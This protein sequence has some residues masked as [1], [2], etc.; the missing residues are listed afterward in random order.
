MPSPILVCPFFSFAFVFSRSKTP[1]SA[2]VGAGQRYPDPSS[3][4]GASRLGRAQLSAEFIRRELAAFDLACLRVMVLDAFPTA[5]SPAACGDL[6]SRRVRG[7][8]T[9]AQLRKASGVCRTIPGG[10]SFGLIRGKRSVTEAVIRMFPAIARWRIGGCF[11]HGFGATLPPARR[12]SPNAFLTDCEN[13]EL[14]P[15]ARVLCSWRKQRAAPSFPIQN[16]AG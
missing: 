14:R 5:R 12:R 11:R 1:R 4:S 16:S 15:G 7:Q 6:R 9:R 13:N 8:E 2:L 10:R 3:D